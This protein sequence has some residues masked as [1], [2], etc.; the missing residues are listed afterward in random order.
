MNSSLTD[1]KYKNN[2]RYLSDRKI[3]K[4]DENMDACERMKGIKKV[5]T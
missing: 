5:S 4:S 3:I 2:K 1:L